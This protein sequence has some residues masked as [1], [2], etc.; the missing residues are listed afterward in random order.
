MT[1]VAIVTAGREGGVRGVTA[2]APGRGGR[3][4][5]GSEAVKATVMVMVVASGGGR[6]GGWGRI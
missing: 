3:V 6:R 1:G 4:A 2:A 5:S